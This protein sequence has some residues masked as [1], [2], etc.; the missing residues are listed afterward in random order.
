[1]LIQA[2]GRTVSVQNQNQQN[3]GSSLWMVRTSNRSLQSAF[4][5]RRLR[6][7]SRLCSQIHP[8]SDVKVARFRDVIEVRT[9]HCSLI[10]SLV[11]SD[12]LLV[13]KGIDEAM[14]DC[15]IGITA[16]NK[17]HKV[18]E[19]LQRAGLASHDVELNSDQSNKQ[20]FINWKMHEEVQH[21]DCF[22]LMQLEHLPD[23]S[24]ATFHASVGEIFLPI[25]WRHIPES[26]V[27]KMF[28]SRRM[29]MLGD[30]DFIEDLICN[31]CQ[32]CGT[33]LS[34]EFGPPM[35]Q[36]SFPL[37]CRK[38]QNGLHALSMIYRPFLLYVW[39]DSQ[40]LPLLVANK[41]AEMLFGKIPAEKVYCGYIREKHRRDTS[42]NFV[43][44][45]NLSCE[46]TANNLNVAK[47]AIG[48]PSSSSIDGKR[49]LKMK[50]VF[51]NANQY[52]IWL[53]LLKL[54]FKQGK[55]SPLKFHVKVNSS[56]DPET[57][58]YEV[59]SISMPSRSQKLFPA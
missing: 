1:M 25:T 6:S 13:S 18:I 20:M 42:A 39:D 17:L 3:N 37:Y 56:R 14:K 32:L 15:R 44:G 16:K 33:P 58:R 31:G 49:R 21:K 46:R 54:L 2:K 9:D 55:N 27:E 30:R 29:Y 59:L 48:N 26:E 34:S 7:A 43:Y 52:L 11:R 8:C 53:L 41:A 23:A 28:I 36:N 10:Q 5:C 51:S 40:C 45:Q 19:W 50:Q 24:K 22:S 35:K 4:P 57:E 38:S 12:E 47:S